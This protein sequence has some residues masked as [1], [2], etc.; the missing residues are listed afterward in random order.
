[1]EIGHFQIQVYLTSFIGYLSWETN[2]EICPDVIDFDWSHLLCQI[3]PKQE[4]SFKFIPDLVIDKKRTIIISYQGYSILLVFF[5][6]Q[7][8]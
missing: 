1:M 7:L 6:F 2:R 3:Y 5:R 8:C 4:Q